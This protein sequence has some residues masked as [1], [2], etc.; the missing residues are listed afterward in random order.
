MDMAFTELPS[1]E[2]TSGQHIA[3]TGGLHRWSLDQRRR[4][5]DRFCSK[6]KRAISQLVPVCRCVQDLPHQRCSPNSPQSPFLFYT[7]EDIPRDELPLTHRK[8]FFLGVVSKTFSQ[9][10]TSTGP[11]QQESRHLAPSDF[12][13]GQSSPNVPQRGGPRHGTETASKTTIT[14]E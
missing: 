1:A 12:Q 4:V 6:R 10:R 7:S 14:F 2:T 11:V 13:H 9:I 8:N 5:T 3:M